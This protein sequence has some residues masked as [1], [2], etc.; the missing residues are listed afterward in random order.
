MTDSHQKL[1]AVSK[2]SSTLA[3][4]NHS[5]LSLN[6]SVVK[7]IGVNLKNGSRPM[8]SSRSFFLSDSEYPVNRK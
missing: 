7:Q 1:L 3:V 2:N 5:L 6:S 8:A 4:K